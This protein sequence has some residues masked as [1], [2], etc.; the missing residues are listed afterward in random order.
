VPGMLRRLDGCDAGLPRRRRVQRAPPE[1]RRRRE[2]PCLQ[3][4]D[5]L[6]ARRRQRGRRA[7]RGRSS[8]ANCPWCSA[9]RCSGPGAC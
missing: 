4:V 5:L 8:T 1:T 9:W 2:D 7:W 3:L 6:R